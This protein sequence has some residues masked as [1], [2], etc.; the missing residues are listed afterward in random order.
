MPTIC[1]IYNAGSR[2]GVEMRELL[3]CC[4][5]YVSSMSAP[6][7]LVMAKRKKKLDRGEEVTSP[8]PRHDFNGCMAPGPRICMKCST[9]SS[10]TTTTHVLH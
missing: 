4:M 9:T 3:F 5:K 10:T 1:I 7:V 8:I 6:T 2:R